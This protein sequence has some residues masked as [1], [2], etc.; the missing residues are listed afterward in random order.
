MIE[1]RNTARASKD[2]AKADEIRERLKG[3]GVIL[4]DGPQG[5]TW[6]LDV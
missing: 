6:R 4:E 5:T 1:D 2:W 3:L